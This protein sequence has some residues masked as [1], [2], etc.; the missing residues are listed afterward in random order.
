M[1]ASP[2]TFT[3]DV[4]ERFLR[5]VVIDT[6]SDPTSPTCPSTEKQKNLGRLLASEL[7]AI[8]LDRRPSRRAWLCLCD[9]PGQYRQEG[10]GDLLLLAHGHFT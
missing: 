2:I 10:A 1:P 4:T 5:Y 6:Q 9:D 8:G 7:Q 3:H